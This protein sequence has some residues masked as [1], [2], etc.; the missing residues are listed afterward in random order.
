M[1]IAT[2]KIEREEAAL[3]AM[4]ED[5]VRAWETGKS[6][7][8]YVLSFESPAAMLRVF[9][10]AR[11]EI[12]DRLQEIGPSSIHGLAASLGQD[13]NHVNDDVQALKEHGLIEDTDDGKVCVPYDVIHADFDL[14]PGERIVGYDNERGKGDRARK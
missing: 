9:T 14:L 1:K 13:A 12:L 8:T 3:D 5:F 2:I 7:D 4:D 6:N 10:P 11:C